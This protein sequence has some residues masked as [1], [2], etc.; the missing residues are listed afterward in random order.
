[1]PNLLTSNTMLDDRSSLR[2]CDNYLRL[3]G[4]INDSQLG[5]SDTFEVE[6]CGEMPNLPQKEFFSKSNKLY[7]ELHFQPFSSE[8]N[9]RFLGEFM[10]ENKTQY[11]S[12]GNAIGG[13]TCDRL[14]ISKRVNLLDRNLPIVH[15]EQTG[16]IHSPDYPRNYPNNIQCRYYFIG[17][18]HERVLVNFF[19]ILL[20]P[21]FNSTCD[22]RVRVD[23]ILLE[24]ASNTTNSFGFSLLSN[25]Q[26]AVLR[27]TRIIR[28]ICDS[29]SE[30]QVISDGSNLLLTFTSN[31][32]KQQ[33]RGFAA[34]FHFVH[35]HQVKPTLAMRNQGGTIT[36]KYT[37]LDTM[38]SLCKETLSLTLYIAT[39]VNKMTMGETS[40]YPNGLRKE[41]DWNSGARFGQ[42][43]SPNFPDRYPVNT[44]QQ[45]IFKAPAG[46]EVDI[47][48]GAFRLDPR[49]VSDCGNHTGD[50]VEVYMG[51]NVSGN[52]WLVL[53]GTSLPTMLRHLK[54]KTEATT[55]SFKADNVANDV[56]QGFTLDYVIRQENISSLT[57]N[58][59]A[60]KSWSN[61]DETAYA[62][63]VTSDDAVLDSTRENIIKPKLRLS[64]KSNI[65]RSTEV[66][67]EQLILSNR[68]DHT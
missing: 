58:T 20:P 21:V 12:Q 23:K 34:T 61:D 37:T 56:E 66:E 46:G 26:P 55:I 24:E 13:T 3:Y 45:F 14:I 38:F 6:L 35:K 42:L 28:E 31:D 30:P 47:Y 10:F 39:P 49:S 33:S 16:Q 25:R 4:Q 2:R 43:R 27:P 48:F 68:I 18:N 52:P 51:T 36:D 62:Q 11:V 50:R 8:H 63:H 5:E 59:G 64:G 17:A 22:Q 32:D 57:E 29:Y 15:Q 53:C 19:D 67:L 41:I 60:K 9:F 54:L 44:Q 7:M 65:N 1:M 40:T